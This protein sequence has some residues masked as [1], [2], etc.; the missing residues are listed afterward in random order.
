[1]FAFFCRTPI[2]VFRSIQ[3]AMQ[4]FKD[5]SC[6]IYIFDTFPYSEKIYDRVKR[7]NIFSET[8]YI[9]DKEYMRKG[10]A[11]DF[12]TAFFTSDFKRLLAEK[13]YDSVF[14]YNVYGSFNELIYNSLRTNNKSLEFNIVEDGP[15]IYHIQEYKKG[16]TQKILFP[17]GGLSPYLDNVSQ[18]WFSMPELMTPLKNGN[19]KEIPKVDRKDKQFVNVINDIFDYDNNRIIRDSRVIFMEECYWS[20]GLLSDGSDLSLLLQLKEKVSTDISVK[21]HPRTKKD[22]F[23]EYFSA[24]P[25]NGIPWEVYA[26]NI[27]MES[28]I[29]LSLSC[30]TM[31]STKLLYGMETYSLLLYPIVEDKVMELKGNS[32]YFNSDRKAKIDSQT[33][34]YTDKHKFSKAENIDMAAKTL[35]E[36]LKEEARA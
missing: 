2:H 33:I 9:H 15:S 30:S 34:L 17:I 29:L 13:K 10:R 8:Y 14:V 19:K 27:D 25:A 6:D 31:V 20:D 36:W 26:L 21:L 18:W 24:V 1:M 28:K 16:M 3:F 7:N 23:S 32:K 4:I 11:E 35:N 22:R 12:K 5:V